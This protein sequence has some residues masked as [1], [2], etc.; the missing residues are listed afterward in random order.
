MYGH[1]QRVRIIL[2]FMCFIEDG[3]LWHISVC[4]FL[5]HLYFSRLFFVCG[6]FF[7]FWSAFFKLKRSV[8]YNSGQTPNR[9]AESTRILDGPERPI[10]AKTPKTPNCRLPVAKGIQIERG[11]C[12]C[13]CGGVGRGIT[14]PAGHPSQIRREFHNSVST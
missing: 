14:P 10:A 4:C 3:A 13:V 12:V 11:V 1:C 9:A 2:V 8:F 6:F 5:I 7:V